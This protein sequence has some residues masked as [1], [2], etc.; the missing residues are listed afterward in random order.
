[1]KL[2]NSQQTEE[3][4]YDAFKLRDID[5]MSS[6][7][8]QSDQI[9]CIHPGAQRLFGFD[10]VIKSWQQIFAVKSDMIITISEPV[11]IKQEESAIHYV[12]ENISVKDEYMGVICATN[13]YRQADDGWKIILHHASAL[14]A[15]QSAPKQFH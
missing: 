15:E 5:L 7:W 8:E 1:V 11:Y 14:M 4:F 2:I 13:I 3:I 12:Q 9:C 6:V 10:A